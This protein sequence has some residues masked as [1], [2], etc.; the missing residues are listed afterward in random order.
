MGHSSGLYAST[1]FCA[2]F[3]MQKAKEKTSVRFE[4]REFWC[5]MYCIIDVGFIYDEDA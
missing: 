5:F 4:I 3:L 1:K 2:M